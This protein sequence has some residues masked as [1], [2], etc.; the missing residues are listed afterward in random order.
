[1]IPLLVLLGLIVSQSSPTPWEQPIDLDFVPRPATTTIAWT[2]E[3]TPNEALRDRSDCA[4]SL[5]LP[6]TVHTFL[7]DD[8]ASE[9]DVLVS[10][11]TPDGTVTEELFLLAGEKETVTLSTLVLG[12]CDRRHDCSEKVR[13]AVQASGRVWIGAEVHG[14][15]SAEIPMR[16]YDEASAEVEVVDSP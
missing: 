7:D 1:M 9:V 11:T 5:T 15:L 3:V 14:S 2:L 12:D 8:V 16:T 6:V 10:L 13:I 4:T